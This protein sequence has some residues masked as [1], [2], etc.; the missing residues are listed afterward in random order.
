MVC[1]DE[2]GGGYLLAPWFWGIVR[3][4]FGGV[5]V[6]LGPITFLKPLLIEVWVIVIKDQG[7]PIL[8]L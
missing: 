7:R 2:T 1:V 3:A 8:T 5:W 6:E 4:C